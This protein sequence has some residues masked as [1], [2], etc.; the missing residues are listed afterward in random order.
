MLHAVRSRCC[1]VCQACDREVVVYSLDEVVP[2]HEK[3]AGKLTWG[4]I[5]VLSLT[6]KF[7]L[8][9]K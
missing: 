2:E 6:Q 4:G 8:P 3:Q 1:H 5:K 7:S 9:A